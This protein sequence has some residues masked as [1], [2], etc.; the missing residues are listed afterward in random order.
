[1][2]YHNFVKRLCQSWR[3]QETTDSLKGYGG[4]K[5]SLMRWEETKSVNSFGFSGKCFAFP[6]QMFCVPPSNRKVSLRNAKVLT[7]HFSSISFFSLHHVPLG[8]PLKTVYKSKLRVLR[9]RERFLPV[10]LS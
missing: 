9:G 10:G 4:G 2:L 1:M 5:K 6:R 8:A 7:I 3:S